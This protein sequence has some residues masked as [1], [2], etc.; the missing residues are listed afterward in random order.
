MIEIQKLSKFYGD[1]AALKNINLSLK[2]GETHVFLGSS[3]SGK[4]TLLRLMSGLIDAD[5]GEV[6]ISG[7]KVSTR[8]QKKLSSQI[9]YVIQEGG[10]F[11]HFTGREN[12]ALAAQLAGWD[13][14]KIS[15]RMNE[16]CQLVQLDQSFLEQ[17]P[18][19]LS[20]GQRQR[21]ALMR[22]L[23]LDPPL[24]LLDEPLGALDPLVRSELQRELKRIF[25]QVRKTVIMVTHDIGEGA[26]FGHTISLFHEGELLQHG[27][28]KSFIKN[29]ASDFVTRFFK[30]QVPPAELLESL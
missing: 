12:V 24:V 17:Y 23:M 11:P 20:G 9:A 28:F 13:K 16:L 22:A 4:S 14:A 3:G 1:R 7:V 2:E 6:S 8:N 15:S 18:K 21:I 5:V 25:N 10:L 26:F 19:Q 30:A 27:G 29:P